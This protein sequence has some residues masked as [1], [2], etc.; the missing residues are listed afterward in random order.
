VFVRVC[1][2]LV[3]VRLEMSFIFYRARGG[4]I[5][6]VCVC[7]F[8]LSERRL[9]IASVFAEREVCVLCVCVSCLRAV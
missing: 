7:V 5:V 4:C 2:G 9:E 6:C 8:V 1:V 3:Y